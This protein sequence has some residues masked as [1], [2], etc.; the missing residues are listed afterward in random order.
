MEASS[1]ITMY[2]LSE[3]EAKASE[4]QLDL[5]SELKLSQATK[6]EINKYNKG[7][8]TELSP[9]LSVSDHPCVI[10]LLICLVISSDLTALNA[11]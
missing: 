6:D 9:T 1:L 2:S 11:Q 4:L 7:A 10:F 3:Y 5:Q 8:V